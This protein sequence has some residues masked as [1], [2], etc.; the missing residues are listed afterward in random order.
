MFLSTAGKRCFGR[1]C[2]DNSVEEKTE[3]QR[4][5]TGLSASQSSV[6]LSDAPA[7]T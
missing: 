2:R 7:V 4:G 5:E 3:K 6:L 1:R